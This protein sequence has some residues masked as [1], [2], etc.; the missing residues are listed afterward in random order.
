M[1]KVLAAVFPR[2]DDD[3]QFARLDASG[4]LP[5]LVQTGLPEG[6]EVRESSATRPSTRTLLF[7]QADRAPSRIAE[8]GSVGTT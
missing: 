2:P 1:V 4:T 3:D 6:C 7:G 5:D 8:G